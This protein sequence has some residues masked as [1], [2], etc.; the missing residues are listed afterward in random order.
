LNAMLELARRQITGVQEINVFDDEF[1][2]QTFLTLSADDITG[3]GQI[4]PIGARHFAE[5]AE[6]IQNLVNLQQSGFGQDQMVM[7]HFSSIKM[8]RMIEDL[9]GF[10]DYE[11]VQENVRVGERQKLQQLEMIGQE[12]TEMMA[13]TSGGIEETDFDMP[14]GAA[15]PGAI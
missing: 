2:I 9:M 15:P 3:A 11:L 10:K 14:Q 7:Q 12:Q 1:N 8:A 4:K 5:K 6:M 13:Q